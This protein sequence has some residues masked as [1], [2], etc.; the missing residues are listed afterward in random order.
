MSDHQNDHPMDDARP[1]GP[2]S[3][4]APPDPCKCLLSVFSMSFSLFLA[5]FSTTLDLEAPVLGVSAER[6]A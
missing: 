6:A 1:V 5:L 3:S 2:I 4:P